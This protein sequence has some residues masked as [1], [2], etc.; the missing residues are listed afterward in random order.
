[1]YKIVQRNQFL[2]KLCLMHRFLYSFN[3]WLYDRMGI[4]GVHVEYGYNQ[5][6]RTDLSGKKFSYAKYTF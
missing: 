1:M 5:S 4:S 2:F 6:F 3:L